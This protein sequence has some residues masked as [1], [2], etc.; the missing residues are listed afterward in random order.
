MT[1]V[2]AQGAY[3]ARGIRGGTLDG[4]AGTFLNIRTVVGA[5]CRDN[6]S[7]LSSGILRHPRAGC[8]VSEHRHRLSSVLDVV[9]NR[10]PRQE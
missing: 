7:L 6:R 4:L 2:V 8:R 5:K 9:V 1:V 10:G 3:L